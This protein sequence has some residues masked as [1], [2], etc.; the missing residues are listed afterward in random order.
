MKHAP[1]LLIDHVVTKV[2]QSLTD[3]ELLK[4]TVEDYMVY[5]TPEGELY[6]KSAVENLKADGKAQ[7]IKRENK[8]YSY[9]EQME[10]MKLR[11]ELEAKKAKAGK[12]KAPELTQKQKELMKQLLAKESETRAR[13][14]AMLAGAAPCLVMLEAV[15]ASDAHG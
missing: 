8:A 12:T 15:L 14:A 5:E 10:E 4:V 1:N 6:D 3:N 11:K 9:K 13:L 7:N 2:T